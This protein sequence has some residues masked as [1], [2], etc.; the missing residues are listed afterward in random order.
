MSA[1]QLWTPTADMNLP[2]YSLL[3][4]DI[5]VIC[6]HDDG[7]QIRKHKKKRINKKWR[8]RYGVYHEPLKKGQ[9]LMADGTMYVSRTTYNLI[10]KK[11]KE[12]QNVIFPANS[13]IYATTST[14]YFFNSNQTKRNTSTRVAA[15]SSFFGAWET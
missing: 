15:F 13:P 14:G 6:E 10:L 4:A 3:S 7:E 2:L 11:P 8:K 12:L 1:E 5:V 9:I